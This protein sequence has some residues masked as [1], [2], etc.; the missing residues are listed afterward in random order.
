MLCFPPIS[1][2][3][4]GSDTFSGKIGK[5]IG[6]VVSNWG[7]KDFQSITCEFFPVHSN[8]ALCDVSNDQYCAYQIC[9]SIIRHE[10]SDPDLQ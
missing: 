4:H 10:A 5:M 2:S 1:R 9:W 3:N 8:E 6:G 7:V